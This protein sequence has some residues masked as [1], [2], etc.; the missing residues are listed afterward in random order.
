M[1]RVT[2][3]FHLPSLHL[4][5]FCCSQTGWRGILSSC[6]EEKEEKP[7]LAAEK[8]RERACDVKMTKNKEGRKMEVGLSNS[9]TSIF[10]E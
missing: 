4:D 9:F 6:L 5:M 7:D 8:E 2:E 10:S 1:L 3:N